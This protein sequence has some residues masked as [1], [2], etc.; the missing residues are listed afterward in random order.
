MTRLVLAVTSGLAARR[1]DALS[2]DEVYYCYIYVYYYCYIYLYYCL[3]TRR[4]E[5]SLMTTLSLSQH[6]YIYMQVISMVERVLGAIFE[7]ATPTTQ[8]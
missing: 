3:A 6:I 4:I 2:D 7:N 5:A 8:A 1:I